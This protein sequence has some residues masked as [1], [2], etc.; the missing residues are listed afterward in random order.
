VEFIGED[1]ILGGKYGNTSPPTMIEH[2][3]ISIRN[4]RG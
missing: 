2:L 4:G 1:Y 3:D